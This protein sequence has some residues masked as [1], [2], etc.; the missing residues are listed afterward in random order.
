MAREATHIGQP[1]ATPGRVL[2]PARPDLTWIADDRDIIWYGDPVVLYS[3]G[4]DPDGAMPG[5]ATALER[6]TGRTRV[7]SL[8]GA[9]GPVV[10]A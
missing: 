4:P 10:P 3:L 8:E 2:P 5:P 7:T 6:V 9:C 1:P